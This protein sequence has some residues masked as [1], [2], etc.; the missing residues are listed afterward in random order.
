MKKKEPTGA[1]RAKDVDVTYYA[2]CGILF[3]MGL[4]LLLFMLIVCFMARKSGSTQMLV[5]LDA[6][7]TVPVALLT[8]FYLRT[9]AVCRRKSRF[10]RAAV[11]RRADGTARVEYSVGQQG[12]YL[13]LAQ[14][15][16]LG[17]AG[18]TNVWYDTK[19]PRNMFFG[20]KPPQK[21]SPYGIANAGVLI[22]LCGIL[23]AVFFLFL[24]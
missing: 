1:V 6:L 14:G 24:R 20:N 22:T 21:A 15:E 5:L 16:K 23:N 18:M 13:E 12:Y 3:V 17:S 10:T 8:A 19:D 4:I 2:A 9:N 11:E 7:L